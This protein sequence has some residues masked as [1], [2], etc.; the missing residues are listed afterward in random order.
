MLME[1]LDGVVEELYRHLLSFPE[2]A[3]MLS[4]QEVKVLKVK[5]RAHWE[6]L[7]ACRFDER[8]ATYAT[9]IG[10]VHFDRRIPPYIYLAAY[11][12]VQ[13]LL[14]AR[15][16]R[17]VNEREDLVGALSSLSRIITL[18]IDL[19]LSAYTRAFWSHQK[20]EILV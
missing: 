20:G 3:R 7:F 4:D 18:D 14:V 16:T 19:A 10:Q 1:E 12:Y 17:T 5:Q 8:F 9:R 15:I 2:V 13:C 11:N 6:Q